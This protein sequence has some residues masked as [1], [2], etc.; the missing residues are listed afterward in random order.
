M[1]PKDLRAARTRLKLTQEQLAEKLDVRRLTII[2]YE[3]GQAQIPRAVVLAMEA[4]S[5][6]SKDKSP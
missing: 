5:R 2:R 4:L 6:R 3:A 1:T